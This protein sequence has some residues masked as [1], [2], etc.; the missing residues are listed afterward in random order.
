MVRGWGWEGLGNCWKY[1][2]EG[3]GFGRWIVK[4]NGERGWGEKQLC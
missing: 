3:L 1:D 4:L 2:D